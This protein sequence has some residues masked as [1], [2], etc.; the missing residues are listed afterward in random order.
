MLSTRG[1]GLRVAPRQALLSVAPTCRKQ[2]RRD[3]SKSA[4]GPASVA[5]TLSRHKLGSKYLFF[6]RNWCL[7]IVARLGRVK[8]DLGRTRLN[9]EHSL[10]G[11]TP[12]KGDLYDTPQAL[13]LYLACLADVD[14]LLGPFCMGHF[15]LQ[16]TAY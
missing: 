11:R 15:E 9:S 10:D 3:L 4:P 6:F 2:G 5:L 16:A 13:D 12:V 14:Y 7:P 8:R 1:S